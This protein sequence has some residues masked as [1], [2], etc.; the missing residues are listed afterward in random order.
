MENGLPVL[1]ATEGSPRGLLYHP[2]S[3]DNCCERAARP[4]FK[5]PDGDLPSSPDTPWPLQSH[6]LFMSGEE[7][8]LRWTLRVGICG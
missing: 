3:G 5:C 6:I 2:S 4:I 8:Y 7:V 1:K